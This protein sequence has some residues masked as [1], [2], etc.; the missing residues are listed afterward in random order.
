M[1]ETAVAVTNGRYSTYDVYVLLQQQRMHLWIAFDGDRVIHGIEVTQII[2]YP[3]K[4][5]LASL[6]T[7]GKRLREW[8][9]PMMDVLSRWARDNDCDAIEGQ[10]REGW[11]K[12]LEPYGVKRGLVNFEKEL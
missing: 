12:M 8:R 11:I 9:E 6:F 1:L 3:S 2:D 5:V 10:G 4:R 7:A